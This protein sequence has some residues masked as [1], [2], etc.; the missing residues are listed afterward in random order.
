M[1]DDLDLQDA[2]RRH[3]GQG[4]ACHEDGGLDARV[5]SLRERL[6]DDLR[7]DGDARLGRFTRIFQTDDE[8]A[9]ELANRTVHTVMHLGWAPTPAAAMSAR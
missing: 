8:F 3:E 1:V 9:A 7:A 2:C 4:R 5:P 6:P